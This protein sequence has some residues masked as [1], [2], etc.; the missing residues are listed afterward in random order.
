MQ[1][2]IEHRIRTEN[3]IKKILRELP[4]CVT[5]Y[6]YNLATSREPKTCE[7]YIKKIRNFLYFISDEPENIVF[8]NIKE[9]DITKYIHKMETRERNGEILPTSFSYRKTIYSILKNFFNYLKRNNYIDDNLMEGIDRTK[10]KDEIKR[11]YLTWNDLDNILETV[12][13]GAGTDRSINRQENWKTRDK[14]I[15]LLFVSTGMRKTALSEINVED[16]DLDKGI[17]TIIDKR[18]KTHILELTEK[19]INILEDWLEQR[20]LILDGIDCDALFI[21]NRRQRMSEKS[22]EN[23]VK[24][25]SDEALGIKLSPHKLRFA[26]VSL[27][28]DETGDIE[29]VRD[30]VGHANIATTQRYIVKDSSAKKKATGIIGNRLNI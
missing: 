14:L 13:N 30:A 1:G 12:D 15:I 18:Y 5:N 22:I 29:F 28:Y 26:Y 11:I 16:I 2:R 20:N 24:K 25:Y 4:E 23:I 10:N 7:E 17:I 27:L 8:N 9:I 21:S 6:Y 3:N 19:T